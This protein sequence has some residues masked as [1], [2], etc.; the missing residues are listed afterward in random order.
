MVSFNKPLRNVQLV[1]KVQKDLLVGTEIRQKVSRRRASQGEM[2]EVKRLFVRTAK[3]GQEFRALP[4][5]GGVQSSS[6]VGTHQRGRSY[7]I[8]M[9]SFH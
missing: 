8:H 2:Q 5:L 7:L 1:P 6:Q 3:S 9:E 4:E